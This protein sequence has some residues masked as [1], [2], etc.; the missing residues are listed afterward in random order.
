M[1][2][3]FGKLFDTALQLPEDPKPP[4]GDEASTRR[5]RAAPNY[6]IYLIVVRGLKVAGAIIALLVTVNIPMAAGY[7]QME[8]H[9][10]LFAHL[11]ELELALAVVGGGL[12]LIFVRL[13]YEKRW[14]LVTDRSFRIR[15]GVWVVKEMTVNFANIQNL[16][17]SQGPVQRLMGIAD[18]RVDTAGGG[19]SVSGKGEHEEENLHTAWFRGINNADEVRALIQQRLAELKDAGLGDEPE[20]ARDL[21]AAGASA[22]VTADTLQAAREVLQEARALSKTVASLGQSGG[23]GDPIQRMP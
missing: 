5:F 21:M 13:D 12:A 22:T 20:P 11:F 18:V 14:Y 16:T 1:F 4:P 17:V 19:G 9:F 6:F 15:E 3:W 10:P 8:S 2:S 7:R 23:P